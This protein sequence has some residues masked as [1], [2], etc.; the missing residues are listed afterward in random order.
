MKQYT[1]HK[2][3]RASEDIVDYSQFEYLQSKALD[4]GMNLKVEDIMG[5]PKLT[6]TYENVDFL[7]PTVTI[8]T[9]S[10]GEGYYY[11][12]VP[13]VEFPTLEFKDNDYSDNILYTI[14][15]WNG[16]GKFLQ[17]L[18]EFQYEIDLDD[19]DRVEHFNLH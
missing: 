6:L 8:K 4:M 18:I 7:T 10:D 11:Y 2:K 15:H 1:I 17:L 5:V 9:V 16:L 14:Q 13:K 3:I 19:E 12:F